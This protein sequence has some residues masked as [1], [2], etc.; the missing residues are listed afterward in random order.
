MPDEALQ[1]VVRVCTVGE[2]A[3]GWVLLT[4]PSDEALQW[5]HLVAEPK[6]NAWKES[7]SGVVKALP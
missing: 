6:I 2:L 1:E 4:F 3:G 7:V 5:V